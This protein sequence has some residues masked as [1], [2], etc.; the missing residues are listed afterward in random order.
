[1]TQRKP[2]MKTFWATLVVFGLL[3]GTL[4]AG[5][6]EEVEA[7]LKSKIDSVLEILSH[8]ELAQEDKSAKIMEA[9]EPI[10]DFDIMAKLTLGKTGWQRMNASQQQ[11]FID[12]FVVRLKASYVDKTS[13]YNDEK[14]A[15]KPAVLEDNK[16]HVPMDI[17]GADGVISVLYKFYSSSQSWKIYDVEINGVSLV[18]SYKS[19]FTEILRNGT[20]DD[21]LGELRK[22]PVNEKTS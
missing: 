16:V 11:E 20:V 14:V 18:Q 13:L 17:I 22:T 1:M 4:A 2:A 19:Q 9:V 5:Q 12:L 3:T 8:K 7:L 10:F 6:K 15:Y 21:L